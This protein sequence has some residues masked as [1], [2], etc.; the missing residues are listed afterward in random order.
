M[1][2]D[3]DEI[4]LKRLQ[5]EKDMLTKITPPRGKDFVDTIRNILINY[6]KIKE[7]Y[8]NI[9]LSDPNNIKLYEN[10]FTSNSV[11]SFK[12]S[13]T[14]KVLEDGNSTENNAIY[15]FYGDNIFENF[16]VWYL[17]RR[18]PSLRSANNVK[19]IARLK[20]NYGPNK[21]FPIF[22]NKY[23][24]LEYTSSSFFERDRNENSLNQNVFSAFL[25]ATSIIFDKECMVNG[26]GY[27]VCYEIL[28]KF[29]NEDVD[30]KLPSKF[31][32]LDSPITTL[33]QF[34]D[35]NKY[36]IG[37]DLYG[38]ECTQDRIN[39]VYNC[40]IKFKSSRSIDVVSSGTAH[41]KKD[42]EKMAAINALQY[43]ENKGYSLETQPKKKNFI[44][45]IIQGDRTYKFKQIIEKILNNANIQEKYKNILLTTE[46]MNDFN[47]AFT[48]NTSNINSYGEQDTDSTENY[49]IYETLGDTIFKNFIGYYIIKR[50]NFTEFKYAKILSRIKINYG[51]NEYFATIVKNLGFLPFI[52]AS[53]DEHS[54]SRIDLSADVFESFLGAV[55]YI[56]D[57]KIKI[58]VG[59]SI[60]YSIL[61]NIFNKIE[62]PIDIEELKDPISILKE[63]F[64]KN[65]DFGNIEYICNR[66]GNL[67]QCNVY[68]SDG[69]NKNL[70]GS[71]TGSKNATAKRNAA[72]NS[73][74]NLKK[75]GFKI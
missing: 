48:S 45:K 6:T 65:K 53:E 36:K 7:D 64:D 40:D 24:F 23:N 22:A 43:L 68:K 72:L 10:A 71:G 16:M 11:N 25:G 59:Y 4:A 28:K 39:N 74:E 1:E 57:N 5:N 54:T 70:L 37:I 75:Q 13:E 46:S 55:A 18:F 38:Y 9:L 14:E 41:L 56:L 15:K 34:F 27:S 33:K 42:A 49:E 19:I 29:F 47:L 12:D 31:E 50:F 61:E 21:V 20:I 51:S 66:Y 30:L 69:V 35:K 63:F 26:V 52:T 17:F 8:I 3:L 32:E 73:V 67:V 44:T 58:G 60:C 62:I 2:P